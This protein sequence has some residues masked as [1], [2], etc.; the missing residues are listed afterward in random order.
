MS[1]IG[2]ISWCEVVQRKIDK[3]ATRR[4]V[5]DYNVVY[6]EKLNRLRK[7]KEEAT[8]VKEGSEC[9]MV[10]GYFQNI[11]QNDILE[12]YAIEEHRRSL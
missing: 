11:K 2:E 6:D 8:E 12:S 7:V 10:L 3:N 9:G 1:K 4:L 5:K